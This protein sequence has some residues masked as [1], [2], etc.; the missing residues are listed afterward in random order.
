MK[1]HEL[2]QRAAKLQM[3]DF[4]AVRSACLNG[5][6]ATLRK[7]RGKSWLS[8][9]ACTAVLA[10]AAAAVFPWNNSPGISELAGSAQGGVE[11][12]ASTVEPDDIRINPIG[13]RLVPRADIGLN[14]EDFV[15]MSNQQLYDY[16]G[17]N[18]FPTPPEGCTEW[19]SE[20]ED[21]I[22][23]RDGGSGEVYYDTIILNYSNEDYTKG[24]H[25][26]AAK[27]RLPPTDV[28]FSGESQ[29]SVING[30]EVYIG[31]TEDG[32]FYYA[33]FFYQGVGFRVNAEGLAQEEFVAVLKS[34]LQ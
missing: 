31:L 12:S 2:L 7:N 34:V 30:Q 21:G 17:I 16:F 26:E 13:P 14:W 3:P 27:G 8:A 4:E 32:A 33:E 20:T 10:L 23:R 28:L 29:P 19:G 11:S 22:F 1:E 24:L 18:I 6:P 5:S 9:A 25:L 15:P